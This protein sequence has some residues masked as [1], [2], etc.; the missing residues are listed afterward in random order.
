MYTVETL[1]A[2]DYSA[3][4]AR[5]IAELLC[6]VW[7]KSEKPVGVR[8]EQLLQLGKNFLGSECQYPRSILIREGGLVIAHA[9]MIPRVIGTSR[10][11]MTVAGLTRVCSNPVYRGKGLGE[12]VV[13]EIFGLV[14]N[15]I[16]PF[17][18]FQT[19]CKVRPFYEK[20]GATLVTNPIG[21]S[22]SDDPQKCPF[23]DDV[24][25][26]YPSDR[27]W[28]TGAIDLRGPGY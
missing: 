6:L 19:S 25:L 14:R 9:G 20:L 3:T 18:L 24:V 11:D 2:R 23:W 1:D 27:D 5:A 16:F 8:T 21:D 15:E 12:I 4:D 17:S 26:R 10:G 28:P 13:R 22:R 7:P